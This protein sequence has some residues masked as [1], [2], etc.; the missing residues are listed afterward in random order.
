MKKSKHDPA[1]YDV[2]DAEQQA[3]KVPANSIYGQTGSKVSPVRCTTVAACTTAWGRR[4]LM[5]AKSFVEEYYK[6]PRLID[7]APEGKPVL[8]I[9]G[10]WLINRR[11]SLITEN[12]KVPNAPLIISLGIR[13]LGDRFSVDLSLVNTINEPIR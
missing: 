12:W 3:M 8:V 7:N 5:C 2:Y 13:L 10:E 6:V 1:L 4:M 9:G 11:A